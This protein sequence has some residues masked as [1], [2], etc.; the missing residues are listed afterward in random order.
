MNKCFFLSNCYFVLVKIIFCFL[1]YY[2]KILWIESFMYNKF[3][4]Y[5]FGKEEDYS[6]VIDKFGVSIWLLLVLN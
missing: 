6:G 1:D 3:I 4:F 2:N 5:K